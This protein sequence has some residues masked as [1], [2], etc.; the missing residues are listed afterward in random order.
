VGFA[1][2]VQL[3]HPDGHHRQHEYRQE[4]IGEAAI[5]ARDQGHESKSCRQEDRSQQQRAGDPKTRG[6]RQGAAFAGRV[7]FGDAFV[8][9]MNTTVPLSSSAKKIISWNS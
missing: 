9:G 6:L 2:R 4:R 1:A 5:T 7:G 8:E 3:P